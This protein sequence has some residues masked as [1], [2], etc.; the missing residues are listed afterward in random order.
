MV[1]SSDVIVTTEG[2]G[3]HG[4]GKQRE[5]SDAEHEHSGREHGLST[6]RIT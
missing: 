2:K 3:R 5:E 6:R 4:G 1:A